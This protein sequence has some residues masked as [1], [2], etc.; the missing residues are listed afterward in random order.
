MTL[1]IGIKC[2]DGIVVASDAAAT[3]GSVGTGQTIRQET[4][5]LRII[6]NRIVLGTSGQV[7]LGQRFAAELQDCYSHKELSDKTPVVAMTIISERFRKHIRAEA[8][9]A[10][11]T[12]GLIGSQANTAWIS[13]SLVAVPISKCLCLF[14]FDHQGAP[15]EKTDEL[16]FACVGSGQGTADPF[17]AFLRRILWRGHLPTSQVGILSAVWAIKHVTETSPGGVAEPIQVV[18]VELSEKVAIARELGEGELQEPRRVIDVL[19]ESLRKRI[20]ELPTTDSSFP[21]APEPPT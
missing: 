12:V 5:K 19:E 7:G 20:T 21:V 10:K 8:E 18:H 1:I 4:K 14:E 2:E 11:I 15:E 17:L 13:A 16:P 9:M 6:E 3:F